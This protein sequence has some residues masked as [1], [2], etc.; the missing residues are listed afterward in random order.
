VVAVIELLTKALDAGA[1]INLK[2]SSGKWD[3]ASPNGFS[4]AVHVAAAQPNLIAATRLLLSRGANVY[5]TAVRIWD[6][7]GPTLSEA[8]ERGLSAMAGTLQ[9][10]FANESACCE[11]IKGAPMLPL[12]LS[13]ASRDR[14]ATNPLFMFRS[15]SSKSS[16]VWRLCRMSCLHIVCRI[17]SYH[18]RPH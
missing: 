5:T 4:P 13:F 15:S 6:F 3:A 16:K 11:V 14:K 9:H 10:D 2:V 8:H 18:A 1:N 12:A 17:N 7:L